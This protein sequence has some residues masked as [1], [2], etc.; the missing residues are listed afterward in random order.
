MLDTLISSIKHYQFPPPKEILKI[1]TQLLKTNHNMDDLFIKK[2]LT[3]IF[4]ENGKHFDDY[5][6]SLQE[7]AN[8]MEIKTFNVFRSKFKNKNYRYVEDK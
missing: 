8:I 4:D 3:Y 5:N 1:V 2:Y 7:I 6:I